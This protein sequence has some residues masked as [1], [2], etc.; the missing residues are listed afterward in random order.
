MKKADFMTGFLFWTLLG[1]IIIVPA[2]LWASQFF[3]LN[4][5]AANSYNE[6]ISL[7][8][9]IRDGEKLSMPLYMDD[10][11]AIIGISKN[12]K[13]FEAKLQQG[14]ATSLT[15]Y[16]VTDPKCQG[17][18]CVCF[19]KE[20]GY[21]TKS[22]Y[23]RKMTCKETS[24]YNFDEIE[25]LKIRPISDFEVP[26]DKFFQLSHW[27]ENGFI[28]ITNS[29]IDSF[30]GDKTL[31]GTVYFGGAINE[32]KKNTKAIYIQRYRNY[33]NVCYNQTCITEDI[34]NKILG[35]EVSKDL[36]DFT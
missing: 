11:T 8:R 32:I 19:C 1:I 27:W 10:A 17:K 33:V 35:E 20:I 18:T 22:T 28:I 30:L 5:A 4:N 12:S 14:T 36:K 2:S 29:R 16:E 34:K 13:R 26:N 23:E 15:Y 25:F 6:M 24:C 7:I 21:E 3:K 31:V 9:G